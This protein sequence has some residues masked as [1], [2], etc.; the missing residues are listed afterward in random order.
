MEGSSLWI[1]ICIVIGWLGLELE[2]LVSG[3]SK[4]VFFFSC[5]CRRWEKMEVRTS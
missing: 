3:L 4:Y 2:K 1:V 5:G